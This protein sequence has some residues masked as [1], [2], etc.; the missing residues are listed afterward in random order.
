M[1][2]ELSESDERSSSVLDLLLDGEARL[3]ENLFKSVRTN[4]VI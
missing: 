1:S 2:S 3:D 4:I